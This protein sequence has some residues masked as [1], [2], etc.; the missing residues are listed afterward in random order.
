M[1]TGAPNCLTSIQSPKDLSLTAQNE[2]KKELEDELFCVGDRR[3][4]DFYRGHYRSFW[5]WSLRLDLLETAGSPHFSQPPSHLG[6][7]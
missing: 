1:M 3:F 5:Q 4:A 6:Y 2:K 7:L